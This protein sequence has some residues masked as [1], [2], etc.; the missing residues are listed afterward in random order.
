VTA[1]TKALCASA[2]LAAAA[3]AGTARADT[4][5]QGKIRA[6]KPEADT[7]VSAAAPVRN[8]G[9]A[10][11]LRADGSPHA[12]AYLRFRDEHLG[13][14]PISV[15]LILHVTRGAHGG[16]EVRPVADDDWR[17]RAL[18][19]VSAPRPSLRYA[20]AKP[21]RRRGWSA[22][23]VTSFV[24]EGD[25][26]LTLAITTRSPLGVTFRSREAKEGP[27]LVIR[28]ARDGRGGERD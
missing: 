28:T 1:A 12:S 15:T 20:S 24:V 27:R 14:E 11:V 3:A 7:Y 25:D 23:D 22:V 16:F 19:Y 4:Q 26:T 9:R 17:E 21:V 8:F 10:P 18:T 5:P 6:P 2:A 13:R